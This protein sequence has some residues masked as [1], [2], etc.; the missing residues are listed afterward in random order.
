MS[1]PSR[2]LTGEDLARDPELPEAARA[3]RRYQADHAVRRYR[4]RGLAALCHELGWPCDATTVVVIRAGIGTLVLR[5]SGMRF[6]PAATA[7][8]AQPLPA[9]PEIMAQRHGICAGCDRWRHERCTVA[10]CR[11]TGMGQP[12]RRSSRCPEGRW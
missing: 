7:T 1:S 5:S 8:P 12:D 11:C 2:D 3:D 4:D 6:M 9:S 10:G